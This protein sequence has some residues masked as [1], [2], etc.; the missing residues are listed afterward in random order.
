[1]TRNFLFMSLYGSVCYLIVYHY[2]MNSILATPIK[3]LDDKSIFDAY[4]LKFDELTA[5]GFKPN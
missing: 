1:M 4:K 5:K 2:K 3:G